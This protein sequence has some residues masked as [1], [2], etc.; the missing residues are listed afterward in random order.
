MIYCTQ[1]KAEL[2]DTAQFCHHCGAAVNAL[3]PTQTIDPAFVE[4]TRR[5]LRW[6]RKAWRIT[7]T[8]YIILGIVFAALYSLIAVASMI[9][10]D[11]ELVVMGTVFIVYALIFGSMFIGLGVVNRVAAKKIDFYLNSIDGDFRPTYKRCSAVGM[12]VLCALF[13]SIA[14][15]FFVINFANMKARKNEIERSLN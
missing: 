3:V 5:L 8:V 15:I 12:I 9:D 1:C 14:F 10:T 13:N 6:E 4:Q 7:G 2:A 11:V